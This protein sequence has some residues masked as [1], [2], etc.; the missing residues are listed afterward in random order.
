MIVKYCEVR[1]RYRLNFV[2]ILLLFGGG[3]RKL[4]N[5]LC[6]VKFFHHYI[7][8][9][10]VRGAWIEIIS[11]AKQCIQKWSHPV[12]GAWIE[13]VSVSIASTD[14]TGRTP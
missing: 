4:I 1:G 10:P 2:I 5:I 9:H 12:R 13:I 14:W 7:E 3:I 6:C 11:E 8:S